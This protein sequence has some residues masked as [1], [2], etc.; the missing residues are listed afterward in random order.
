MNVV[1]TSGL[2]LP[3]ASN[4]SSLG[5]TLHDT[6]IMALRGLMKIRRTPEQLLD[7]TLQPIIFTLLF[8]FIFGGAVA[9]DVAAYLPLVIP[10]ILV[11]TVLTGSSATG[12]QLREDMDKGVFDRFRTLPMAR[13]APLAG[14]L[15]ADIVRY[16]IAIAMT[17]LVG[18]LLGWRPGGGVAGVA[19]AVL[20]LVACAWALSWIFA[21]LGVIS[22][23]AS[24]VQGLAFLVLLPLTFLSNAYVPVDTL[25]EWLQ[26]FVNINPVTHLIT[27]LRDLLGQ[28]SF[29]QEGLLALLGAAILVAVMAPLT[30][31]VYKTRV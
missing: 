8:T 13:I 11:Q 5:Q 3:A 21:F 15:T 23:S 9:G 7:V 20:L 24:G 29:G 26:R 4:R 22:R 6:M 25:P 2:P 27:A 1:A 30:V 19:G 31:R 16:L 17:M 14:A 10:G 12:T 28:G 18:G